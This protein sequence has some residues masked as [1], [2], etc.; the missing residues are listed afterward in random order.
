MG[1]SGIRGRLNSAPRRQPVARHA[2]SALAGMASGLSNNGGP[3]FNPYSCYCECQRASS[4]PRPRFSLRSLTSSNWAVSSS[5][6]NEMMMMLKKVKGVRHKQFCRALPSEALTRTGKKLPGDGIKLDLSETGEVFSLGEI[7][8]EQ[9]VG[10][11]VDAALPR[12][13]RV[14]QV[15]LDAG[16]IG[17]PFGLS[18]F[19]PPIV[20]LGQTPAAVAAPDTRARPAAVMCAAS[21]SV[22]L[23]R[24]PLKQTKFGMPHCAASAMFA[25]SSCAM[26]ACCS[27][28][29]SPSSIEA[30]PTAEEIC[31]PPSLTRA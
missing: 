31:S 9:A 16:H 8:P 28:R 1:L 24:L 21:A 20:S 13:V 19:T 5:K 25:P 14:G 2:A 4:S 17:E 26:R 27:A 3:P 15:D 11:L 30:C 7:L 23:W 10:V 12:T 22:A 6:C 29:Y 18:H